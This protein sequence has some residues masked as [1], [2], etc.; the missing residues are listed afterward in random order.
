MF[1][2]QIC[3]N[4]FCCLSEKKK[5]GLMK[6]NQNVFGDNIYFLSKAFVKEDCYPYNENYRISIQCI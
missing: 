3:G 5:T 2:F 6:Y 1:S 4:K